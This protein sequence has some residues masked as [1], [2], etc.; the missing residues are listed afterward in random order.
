LDLKTD[1]TALLVVDGMG[2]EY[3]PLLLALAKRRDMNVESFV[4]VSA[5]LPTSTEFN[6]IQWD[7]NRT[8]DEVRDVDNIAHN[9]AAKHERCLPER[10]IAAVLRVF[11]TEV[12]NRI[13]EGL[14]RFSR[15]VVT[16]DHGSSRLAVLAY[17]ERYGTTLPW[18]R[19]PLDWRYSLAPTNVKRPSEFEG[20]YHPDRN[21]N[22]GETYWAVRGYNRLP[23]RGGKLNELHGGASLEE[24][25]V[26]VVVFT[27]AEFAVQ[28]RQLDKK[29]T[30]QIID[31]MGFDI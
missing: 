5:K 1:D 15:V 9:G 25:L 14:S 11:E 24:W 26:P 19:Q 4:V 30:E 8:L 6:N 23:K 22:K 17:N 13:A 12:F 10:N 18:N 21:G 16:G 20:Q 7:T 2:A 28:P 3:L 29:T 27:K 31:K